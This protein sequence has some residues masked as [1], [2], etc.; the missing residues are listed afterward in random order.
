MGTEAVWI[1]AVL[2]AVGA[3][4]SAKNSYDTAKRQDNEAAAGIAAQA[5]RQ[6]QADDRVSQEVNALSASSPEAEREQATA[7]FMDQLKRTR[8]QQYDTSAVGASSDEFNADAKRGAT[9]VVDFGKKRAANMAAISAPGR[10]RVN[11][12]TGFG[13]L[14][15]DL[16]QVGRAANGDAFLSQLR[17]R[18]IQRNPWVDAGASIAGGVAS[19]MAQNTGYGDGSN[20]VTFD[21]GYVF[22]ERLPKMPKSRYF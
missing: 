19:G 2:S 16:N 7:Q 9:N 6:Q 21:N 12:Q 8:G 5:N 13:R 4:A 20:P 14:G 22:D 3:G 17:Q 15:G 18:G 11:E 1:P 10:Q